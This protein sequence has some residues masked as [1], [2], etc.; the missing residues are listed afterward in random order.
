MVTQSN[1]SSQN[2]KVLVPPPKARWTGP[3]IILIVVFVALVPLGVW[4]FSPIGPIGFHFETAT[5]QQ[6]L[7]M[8][9]NSLVNKDYQTGYRLASSNFRKSLYPDT[10]VSYENYIQ[11]NY[12][13]VEHLGPRPVTHCTFSSMSSSNMSSLTLTYSDGYTYPS[14]VC[15]AN[16]GGNWLLN[17]DCS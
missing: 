6:T 8:F 3:I 16:E 14:F 4:A 2:Q 10:E 13:D 1:G 11:F 9:C 17:L 12:E 15:L 7:Q 5:P